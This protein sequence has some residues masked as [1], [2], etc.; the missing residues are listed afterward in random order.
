MQFRG[1]GVLAVLLAAAIAV[2]PVQSLAQGTPNDA[3]S[4]LIIQVRQS[5]D[6]GEIDYRAGHLEAARVDFDHAFDLLATS[7]ENLRTDPRWQAEFDRVV[8]GVNRLEKEALEQGDGFTERKAEPAPIDA[9]NGIE[10]TVDPKVKAQ[11]EA[12]LKNT[13]SD[14]PLM[15]NDTVETSCR[16]LTPS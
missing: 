12:E 8:D 5:Y 4:Q 14:L 6:N 15:L 11:A 13:R 16:A 1:M 2:A 3:L 10:L 9:I 7:P